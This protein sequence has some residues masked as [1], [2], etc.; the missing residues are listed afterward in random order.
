[1]VDVFVPGEGGFASVRIPAVVVGKGGAV[2]AFAEGRAAN[3]DQAKNKIILKRSADGGRTWG[4]LAV[5]AEDGDR[6]LNNPCA[7]VE[8]GSGRVLLMYQSYPAGIAE[9]SGKIATGYEGDLVVRT[10]LIASDDEGVTWSRPRDLTR[11]TKRAEGVTTIASG[12]GIGV[13]LRHGRHAGRLVMPFN[14]GPFGVWN[15]YAVYSDD[16]GETWRM[17][18][19]APGGFTD[20]PKGKVSTVNEAQLVELADGSVRFNVRRWAGKPVRKTCV[21]RDGGE[22]WSAVEDATELSDPGCMGSVVRLTDP[23]DGGKSRIL[24]SGPR[25]EKREKG[26]VYVSYDEGA[27]WP[28][29]RVLCEGSFAYSCLA[30]L[31]DGMIGCLYETQGKVVFARF[32]LDWLTEGAER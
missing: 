28:V 27:T 22:T 29:S 32:T 1:V 14:E 16:K 25:G 12:P 18:N 10:Y 23:A 8:R 21:S 5:I 19:V 3:A 11:Q 20:G 9:R 15:I 4:K 6:A 24:F 31:P 30:P 26:T 17:G 7:V 13:Q 2:L